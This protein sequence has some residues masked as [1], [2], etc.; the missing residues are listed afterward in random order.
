MI[1]GKMGISYR[2]MLP[3]GLV[4]AGFP[5]QG[6]PNFLPCCLSRKPAH[7]IEPAPFILDSRLVYA[8]T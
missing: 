6:R 7:A 8:L 3:P 4:H 2:K 1:G 5:S